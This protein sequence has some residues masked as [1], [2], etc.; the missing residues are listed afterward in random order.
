MTP[1]LDL[2]SE[3]NDLIHDLPVCNLPTILLG[4]NIDVVSALYASRRRPLNS[5]H[6]GTRQTHRTMY[7]L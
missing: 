1:R 3:V 6:V 2:D 7:L 4:F 5:S